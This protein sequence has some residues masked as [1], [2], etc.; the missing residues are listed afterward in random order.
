VLKGNGAGQ[1][2]LIEQ[3]LA[4]QRPAE[5]DL[6]VLADLEC[7]FQPPFVEKILRDKNFSQLAAFFAEIEYI[8]KVGFFLKTPSGKVSVRSVAMHPSAASQE[9][10]RTVP[11]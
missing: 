8:A 4:D 2:F 3:I 10:A 6:F 1:I 7:V 9:L 5:L 11:C